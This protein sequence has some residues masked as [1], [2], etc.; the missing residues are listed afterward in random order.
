[1]ISTHQLIGHEEQHQIFRGLD[2]KPILG[3]SRDDSRGF[4]TGRSSVLTQNT[5]TT[6]NAFQK[7][8]AE[9]AAFGILED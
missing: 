6:Y 5:I 7:H 9:D 1:M 8:D 4:S 2:W 3:T